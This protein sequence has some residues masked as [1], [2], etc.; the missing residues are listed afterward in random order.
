MGCRRS[1]VTAFF[2]VPDLAFSSRSSS[3]GILV[4]PL[5]VWM[6]LLGVLE[7]LAVPVWRWLS[8]PPLWRRVLVG[9]LWF[10]SYALFSWVDLG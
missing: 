3:W 7:W 2:L 4:W 10:G 1:A 5:G 8:A 9:V 6:T